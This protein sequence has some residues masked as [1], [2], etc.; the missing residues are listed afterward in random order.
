MFIKPI[1]LQSLTLYGIETVHVSIDDLNT[2]ADSF[3]KVSINKEYLAGNE[4]HY[5]QL[6]K[7]ELKMCK[8]IQNE[9]YCE[10]LFVVKHSNMH[11]YES[12]LFYYAD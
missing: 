2:K 7:K 12:A 8:H 4:H 1:H 3:S 11:T 9:H 10:E 5:I 6:R